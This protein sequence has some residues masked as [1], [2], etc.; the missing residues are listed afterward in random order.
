MP[1][2][3]VQ[4]DYPIT[5]EITAGLLDA[6]E[7]G[8]AIYRPIDDARDFEFVYLNPAACRIASIDP[9]DT[10]GQPL[11]RVMR[12][13]S[14]MGITEALRRVSRSGIPE[15]LPSRY[16][17]DDLRAGW[18]S[19]D[20]YA[21]AG[22]YL[23]AIFRDTG[24]QTNLRRTID[25]ERLRYRL[26]TSAL[27]EGI[28]DYDLVED[29]VYFSPSWKAQLGYRDDELENSFATFETA[30]AAEDREPVLAHLARFRETGE[31]HWEHTFHLR[32]KDGHYVPILARGTPVRDRDGRVTRLL[33][34]H[35]DLT[36]TRA[37]ENAGA[38]QA[39]LLASLFDVLP[40]LFVLMDRDGVIHS[41]HTGR[42]EDLVEPA[43]AL[44]GRRVSDVLPPAVRDDLRAALERAV[45]SGE[46]AEL[47]YAL[48]LQG[49]KR[50]F[51][52][53]MA[54]TGDGERVACVV[55]NI[56]ERMRAREELSARLRDL[57]IYAQAVASTQDQ[58]AAVD[59]DFRY[60]MVNEAYA[61]FF[62]Y[63]PDEL[64]GHR[65]EELFGGDAL[66]NKVAPGLARCLKGENVSFEEW[67]Q[68]AVGEPR[69]FKVVYTPLYDG[70]AMLGVLASAHDITALQTAQ[71]QLEQIAHH[72]PLTGLPNRLQLDI[73][74]QRSLKQANRDGSQLAVMFIDLDRFK[75]INDSLG[76]AAGDEVLRQAAG[77]L[78]GALRDS[79]SL[80]RVGGDEFVAVLSGV[81]DPANLSQVASK[82]MDAVSRPFDLGG[83]QA[84]LSC[85]IGISLYPEDAGSVDELLSNADTAMYEAKDQGRNDWRFYTAAMTAQAAEYLALVEN[86]RAALEGRG[87]DIAFH[88]EFD[89]A[90][91]EVV[92]I[93]ALTRW[94]DPQLGSVPP[95]RFIAAAEKAGLVR[96]LDFQSLDTACAHLAAWQADG[97]T[98]PRL[99]MNLSPKTLNHADTP[100]RI[101]ATL[102]RHGLAPSQ[103]ELEVHERALLE[104]PERTTESMEKLE[105]L[106]VGLVVDGFGSGSLGLRYLQALHVRTLK[107]DGSYLKDVDG[108]EGRRIARAMIAMS[109]ALGLDVVLAGVENMQQASFLQ[110]E[111]GVHGQGYYLSRP[112]PAGDVAAF[113]RG[114]A[115]GQSTVTAA[116]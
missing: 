54:L 112:L 59:K 60:L 44:V 52:A 46:P 101:A 18:Y 49:E 99:G 51:E 26:L 75:T 79:D 34:V 43:A 102:R 3:P 53:R 83:E 66:R 16:Y 67:R 93:E 47:S 14:A 63:Q 100:A 113:L 7:F 92:A 95:E 56:S 15:A 61:A 64:I 90:T 1:G 2:L 87:L 31:G 4:A 115:H 98:P 81:R 30:L 109:R 11:S 84:Q 65:V 33:G 9:R 21:L 19:N 86:L 77:R 88:P 85:S 76:H 8:V 32:H 107:I 12:G 94:E 73:I 68:P 38:R 114:G 108:E 57:E 91:G 23:A 104:N 89:V 41:I 36:E 17:E 27:E 45:A 6:V 78:L 71:A 10:L 103:L 13:A 24:E 39:E 72:D 55:R 28:W 105:A 37:L 110:S 96:Q 48:T 82:L 97:I 40:D 20:L 42:P 5:A 25:Q 58:L 70:E 62:G 29:R 35:V 106:G 111:P 80:A 69:C 50:W 74:L 116:G 22:G